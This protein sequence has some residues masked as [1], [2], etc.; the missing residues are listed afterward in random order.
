MNKALIH[1]L[2]LIFAI[3]II[4]CKYSTNSKTADIKVPIYAELEKANWLIGKWQSSSSEGVSTE[5]WEKKNDSTF[6]GISYFVAGKDTLSSEKINLEQKGNKLFY[7]PTVNNQN[8]GKP[9]VFTMT[10]SISNQLIFENSLHDF[11]QIITY[12]Q[13]TKDSLLAVISGKINGIVN[14]QDFPMQRIK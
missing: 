2:M 9:I 4:S 13:I 7:I 5:I 8:N 14:S 1:L 10:S 11:P 3:S 12:K 6:V